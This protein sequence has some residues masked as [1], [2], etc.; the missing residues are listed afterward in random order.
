MKYLL[1]TDWVVDYLVGS[2]DARSLLLRLQPEGIAISV[3]TFTEVYEGVYASRDPRRAERGFREFLR[4]TTVLPFS[5]T[6]A[7]R[8]ARI[9][10]DLRRSRRPITHRA[11][12]LVIA[13]TALAQGLTLVTHNT[14]DYEDI[15]DLSLNEYPEA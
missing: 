9:R 8:T 4:L 10:R 3:V 13:A 6:I 12:D 7:K 15:L 14:K 11:L 2:S 5:R 1:D